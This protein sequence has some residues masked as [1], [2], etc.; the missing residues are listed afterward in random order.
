VTGVREAA[1]E[2]DLRAAFAGFDVREVRMAAGGAATVVLRD[3]ARVA[4]CIAATNKR[5]VV[6]GSAV[7][8][9]QAYRDV[10][11][12]APQQAQ[13]QQQQQQQ[14]WTGAADAGAGAATSASRGSGPSSPS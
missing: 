4:E 7:N 5:V 2:A 12:M 10:P 6:L 14:Q 8:V 9:A 11:A 3:P 13:Q 1:R